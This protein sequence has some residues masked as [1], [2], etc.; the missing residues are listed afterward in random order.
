[1]G[2]PLICDALCSVGRYDAAYRLLMQQDCPSW[3]YAVTMGATTIWERWDSLL[4]DGSIN[5]GEMTSFNHYAF[6]AVADWLH[7]TVG[8]LA[9]AEPGY[10]RIDF[11]PRPGGGLSQA[12]VRHRTP[13]GM[14]EC[15]WEIKDGT[16]GVQVV[17]PPNTM[18]VVALPGSEAAPVEVGSG[19]HSWSYPYQVVEPVR[20]S[21]TID[22]TLGEIIDDPEAWAAVLFAIRANMPDYAG[23]ELGPKD[24]IHMTVR[25]VFEQH[26]N[27]SKLLPAI[28]AALAGLNT[29]RLS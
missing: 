21:L 23:G 27:K 26:P 4:P 16:I 29:M 18:A 15:A 20:A 22:N 11:R 13:Y 8:G 5:P 12:R 9:P 1:V 6:G 17:V 28:A 24:S 19:T 2:T 3:L 14:A 10:S 25:R 7:R